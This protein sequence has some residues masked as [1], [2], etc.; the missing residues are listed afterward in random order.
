[1]SD[2]GVMLLGSDSVPVTE[3]SLAHYFT[4]RLERCARDRR[5]RPQEDTLWYLGNLLD[6][7]GRSDALFS[8]DE[9]GLSL[10]PLALVYGD[11]REARSE[12]ERCLLLRHLGDLALFLGALFPESYARRGI[13]RDYFVGMGASA[14]DYLGDNARRNRHVFA[15]LASMFS[16]VL[17]LVARSCDRTEKLGPR[18]V[19]ALYR[20]WVR[21]RDPAAERRLRALGVVLDDTAH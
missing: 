2:E 20:R 5:P 14:Y 21:D 9:E 19:L 13:R 10:R 4:R 6:R 18:E 17:E 3:Q 8:Q 16:Q 15:E 12:G 1:M 7:F 11:A